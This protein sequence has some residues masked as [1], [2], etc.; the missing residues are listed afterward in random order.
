MTANSASRAAGAEQCG[1][2]TSSHFVVGKAGG[3]HQDRGRRRRGLGNKD[4]LS[5]RQVLKRLCA[6]SASAVLLLPSGVSSRS[7]R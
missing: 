4:I 5:R 6:R 7:I 2:S 1:T 3:S